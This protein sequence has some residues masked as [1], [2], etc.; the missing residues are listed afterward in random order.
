MIKVFGALQQPLNE[1][2]KEG[3]L[4]EGKTHKDIEI[5][6]KFGDDFGQGE[7]VFKQIAGKV[8]D[9]HQDFNFIQSKMDTDD[10]FVKENFR[11]RLFIENIKRNIKD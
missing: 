1:N 8:S 6:S 7:Q 4:L 5:E 2:R 10:D 9:S 11:R 3:K